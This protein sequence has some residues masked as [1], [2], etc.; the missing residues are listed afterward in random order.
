M[1]QQQQVSDFAEKLVF[2]F[3]FLF[4]L[5]LLCVCASVN[6][7][8]VVLLCA[9]C[10]W[11]YVCLV[12]SCYRCV[13]IWSISLVCVMSGPTLYW[14][15]QT[16]FT[17]SWYDGESVVHVV[18]DQ[19]THTF[20]PMVFCT[21]LQKQNKKRFNNILEEWPLLIHVPPFLLCP[22]QL[23]TP[24]GSTSNRCLGWPPC[25]PVRTYCPGVVPDSRTRKSPSRV[26]SLSASLRLKLPWNQASHCS[27]CTRGGT[28]VT[29]LGPP[30]PETPRASSNGS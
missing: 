3:F 13:Y 18:T 5:S 16:H 4:W 23:T 22:P 9:F 30:C 8:S 26:S 14:L 10:I 27:C 28:A 6:V 17:S 2:F 11:R 1:W 25:C 19:V 12:L 21:D 24:S 29:E 7:L 15:L 20:K